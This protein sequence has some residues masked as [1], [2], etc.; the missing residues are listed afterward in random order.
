[1]LFH[2]DGM[3]VR[4]DKRRIRFSFVSFLTTVIASFASNCLFCAFLARFLDLPPWTSAAAVAIGA[5][6]WLVD[7]GHRFF[8]VIDNEGRFIGYERR[9]LGM[10]RRRVICSF[11]DIRAVAVTG[12]RC[13]G[14]GEKGW[15]YAVVVV[16]RRGEFFRLTDSLRGGDGLETSNTNGRGLAERWGVPFFHGEA[17]RMLDVA[18]DARRG[19][20]MLTRTTWTVL[21]YL[22]WL[23][24]QVLVALGLKLLLQQ[25][26]GVT[27]ATD[28]R[29]S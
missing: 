18:Y 19:T 23:A 24:E 7:R 11:D 27:R 12:E 3:A 9:I 10:T 8:H 29:R 13:S 17:E 4:L 21:Y 26:F 20:I 2:V 14:R 16:A 25:L 22:P 5:A 6:A 28:H 1:M 15:G